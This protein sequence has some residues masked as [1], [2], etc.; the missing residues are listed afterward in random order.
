MILRLIMALLVALAAA[1]SAA[2]AATAP[3]DDQ[4][5]EPERQV[6]V[7]IKMM[8]P[9]VRAGSSYGGSYGDAAAIVARRRVAQAIA[10]HNGLRLVDGWPM[11]ILSVDCYVMTLPAGRSVEQT[12]KDL[13]RDP[14]VAWSQPLQTYSGLVGGA[15]SDPLFAAQPD[16]DA[17][18]LA[19]LH[20]LATGRRVSVAIID[21]K[22]DTGHPDLSGQFI[23]DQDFVSPTKAAGEQ[24]GTAVAG[25]IAAKSGNG[26]GVVGVAPEARLMALRACWQS[27]S[28]SGSFTTLCNSL[29]LARALQFA[30]DH[31]AKVINLS[32]GGPPDRLLEELIK[33]ALQ[34]RAT[35]V[36]AINPRSPGGGFPAALPGVVAVADNSSQARHFAGYAAPGRDIPT[37]QPGGGWSLVNGSSFA[38]AHVSGLVALVRERRPAGRVALV[39]A[40]DGSIDACSTLVPPSR[41]CNCTCLVNLQMANTAKR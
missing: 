34:R 22:V 31:D 19:E 32:I 14:S 33:L 21:S 26:I 23:A 20:R 28:G 8:P 29:T 30:I 12:I 9:H 25:I 6:L 13:A 35:V 3:A 18:H 36:A 11:A 39:R 41:A 40:G 24:H 5:S 7:M 38:A 1:S 2:A 4:Q 37:T 27:R 16:A 17:W 10:R 15:P